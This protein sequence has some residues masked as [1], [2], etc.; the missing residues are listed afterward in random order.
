[1]WLKFFNSSTSIKSYPNLNFVKI[2][3]EK[4]L[5]LGVVS[6]QVQ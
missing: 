3:L 6:V 5:F 4:P 1:M 2:W